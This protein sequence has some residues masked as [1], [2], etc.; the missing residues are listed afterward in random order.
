[1]GA[2]S[3]DYAKIGLRDNASIVDTVNATERVKPGYIYKGKIPSK[4]DV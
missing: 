3:R 2:S 4:S 1:M